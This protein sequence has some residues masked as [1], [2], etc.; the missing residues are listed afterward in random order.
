[1]AGFFLRWVDILWMLRLQCVYSGN[2]LNIE[3]LS[4]ICS[5]VFKACGGSGHLESTHVWVPKTSAFHTT[6]EVRT[7]TYT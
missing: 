7:S 2:S 1:M 6:L 3:I 5:S 4:Q